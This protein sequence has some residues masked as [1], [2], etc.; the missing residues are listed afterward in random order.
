E[1][2]ARRAEEERQRVEREAAEAAQRE[3]ERLLRGREILQ[4]FVESYANDP[5]FA[6]IV[7]AIREFLQPAMQE[8]A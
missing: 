5:E 4:A 2:E 7:P 8:A 1:A 6:S 3:R